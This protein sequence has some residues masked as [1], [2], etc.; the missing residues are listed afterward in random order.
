MNDQNVSEYTDPRGTV[1]KWCTKDSRPDGKPMFCARRECRSKAEFK[2][3]LAKKNKDSGG[4]SQ[5]SGMSKDF[6]IAMAAM[7]K[8]EDVKILEEQFKISLN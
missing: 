3:Y 2:D 8:P 6:K 1:F 4:L 7:L 5:S